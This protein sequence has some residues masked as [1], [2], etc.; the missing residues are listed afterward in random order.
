MRRW[1]GWGD[2]D[3]VLSLPEPARRFLIDRLG[4]AKPLPDVPYATVLA[5]L[6]ASALKAHRRV[7]TTREE[8]LRH[9]RGQSIPD[10]LALRSGDIG[11]TPDGIAY[12]VNGEEV[13]EL[14]RYAAQRGAIV[15]PY[16]GGTSVVGH[17]TPTSDPRPVL[18][19]DLGRMN[20]LLDLDAESRIATFGPGAP[21]PQVEAQ[22]RAH[23]HMLGHFPQSFEYS[24]LGGWVATRNSTSLRYAKARR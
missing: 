13:R 7:V 21:G 10:L 24:T 9:A 14:L 20:Q 2:E 3:V 5:R 12:P 11:R 6:P 18:T 8:R 16:G 4:E 19:I 1:N 17:I 23:G 22:L 15:I